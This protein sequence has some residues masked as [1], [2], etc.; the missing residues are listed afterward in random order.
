MLYKLYQQQII[1]LLLNKFEIYYTALGINNLYIGNYSI[2]DDLSR[3]YLTHI[4]R[5]I[6]D[7][8]NSGSE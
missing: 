6:I 1:K 2:L 8:R 5:T 3:Y 7:S 4:N